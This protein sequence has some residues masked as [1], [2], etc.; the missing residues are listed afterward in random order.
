[1]LTRKQTI[2]T[3]GYYEVDIVFDHVHIKLIT[4]KEPVLGPGLLLDRLREKRCIYAVASRNEHIDNLCVWRCRTIYTHRSNGRE[5]ELTTKEALN[6]ARE[7][8]EDDKLKRLD[9]RK[10]KLK[11]FEKIAK[12]P[13]KFK[14]G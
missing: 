10:T 9:E 5:T 13:I 8:Y 14:F 2:E 7:Y 1:M 4:T 3:P 11:D 12:V 6:L